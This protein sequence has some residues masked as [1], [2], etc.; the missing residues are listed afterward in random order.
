MPTA[1]TSI[2]PGPQDTTDRPGGPAG[3]SRR[4]EP[5]GQGGEVHP[6]DLAASDQS[7]KSSVSV[8]EWMWPLALSAP[9]IVST[10]GIPASMNGTWSLANG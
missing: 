3:V 1:K 5:A 2:R 10:A 4:L 9:S 6:Q 7:M 8:A